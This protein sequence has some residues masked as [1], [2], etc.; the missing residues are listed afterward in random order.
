MDSSSLTANNDY[1][2]I[3]WANCTS[4]GTND[5]ATKLS[6][7]GG[8]GDIQGSVQERHDTNS[9]GMYIGHI[10]Q[11]TAPDPTQSIGIYRKRLFGSN[12]ETTSY[13]QCFIIDLSYSGASGGLVSGT[14]FNSVTTFTE[15]TFAAGATML[16]LT[17]VSSGTHLVLATSRAYDSIDTVLLGLYI[18]DVLVASGSRFIQ[19]AADMKQIL[20]AGAYNIDTG[21]TV[22]IKNLEASDAVTTDYGYIYS[23]NLDTGPETQSTQQFTTWTD[24]SS[25]GSWGTKTVDGNKAPSFIVAMGRQTNT[26]SESGRAA[27]I[28]LK[29]NTTDEWLA[30]SSRPSGDFNSLYF[31]STYVGQDVGQFETAVIIGVGTVGDADSIEMVTI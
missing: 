18:D 1:L 9:S 17:T 14:D 22:K 27:A 26:G 5:G 11:F 31:P 4:P 16:T 20:F 30:F 6:F 10:G 15:N 24:Y 25:S 28:S 3:N 23:L 8:G 12:P 2:I 7:E 19:D 13:G 21:G 29:N